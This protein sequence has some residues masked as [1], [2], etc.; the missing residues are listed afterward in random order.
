M[1]GYIINVLTLIAGINQ[2]EWGAQ[3]SWTWP[4]FE[5]MGVEGIVGRRDGVGGCAGNIF[6]WDFRDTML[7][8]CA[9]V[10]ES[11][12]LSCSGPCSTTNQLIDLG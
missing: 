2:G 9:C 1:E 3:Q 11:A 12:N 4:C 5:E 10:L 7:F 8:R 6:G